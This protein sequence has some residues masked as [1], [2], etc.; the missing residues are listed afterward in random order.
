M[1]SPPYPV[2]VY[3]V[4]DGEKWYLSNKNSYASGGSLVEISDE[5]GVWN[6][7]TYIFD[8]KGINGSAIPVYTYVND[9]KA[10][11]AVLLIAGSGPSDYNST[12]GILTPF[13]D[14]AISL[15]RNGINSLRVDKRTF[16]YSSETGAA[17][18]STISSNAS[19]L[20]S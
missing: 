2:N 12:V 9:A 18:S 14:I 5:I 16:N 4:T 15:A 3:T 19:F 1:N 6:H 7:V 10:H 13:E 17:C 11:P 8:I 20:N